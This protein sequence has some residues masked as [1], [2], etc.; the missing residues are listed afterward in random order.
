MLNSCDSAAQARGLLGKVALAVGMKDK[1]GDP[2]ALTFATRLYRTLAEG[3][4]VQAA[5]DT[6]RADMELNGLPDH[7]LPVLAAAD[8]VD[9][10][11]VRLDEAA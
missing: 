6:A 8:G 3:Q 2:D 9:P 7:D 5:L 11:L 1:V 10:A 4:S